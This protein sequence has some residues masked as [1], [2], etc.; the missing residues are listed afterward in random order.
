VSWWVSLEDETTGD[1]V[2][3]DRHEDGGT[4]AVGGTTEATINVTYN[5]GRFFP[6]GDLDGKPAAETVETIRAAVAELGI[7]RNPD[8]WVRTP[9]NAGYALSILLRWAEQHPAAVWR[10]N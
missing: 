10:V 1:Y 9:G 7:E 3:V 2:E 4:Y 6:F 5:Y 8:Y